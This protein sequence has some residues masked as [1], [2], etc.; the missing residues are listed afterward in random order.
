MSAQQ[1]DAGGRFVANPHAT[2][3][4][5]DDGYCRWRAYDPESGIER[6]VYVH[7]LLACL[8]HDTHVVFD[9]E[10]HVHHRD[11]VRWHNVREN[12]E[13]RERPEH[14]DYHLNGE[15]LE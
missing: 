5:R 2:Y 6:R 9:P 12:L 11:G 4:S 13:V 15:G 8:D 14:G 1:R 7:Q 10:T 3:E